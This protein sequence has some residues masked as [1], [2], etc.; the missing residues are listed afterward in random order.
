MALCPVF[1]VSVPSNIVSTGQLALI[2]MDHHPITKFQG[3]TF[4]GGSR[5]F[6]GAIGYVF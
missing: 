3:I 5:W 6:L 2:T 4:L 1:T